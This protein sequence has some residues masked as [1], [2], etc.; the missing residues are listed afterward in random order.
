[1]SSTSNEAQAF[2]QAKARRNLLEAAR[3]S[4]STHDPI[5]DGRTGWALR[6]PHLKN[7]VGAIGDTFDPRCQACR[8]R[9]G[10]V[11]D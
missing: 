9:A 8:I 7:E 4:A 5:P 2:D 6:E 3:R 11:T 1:M 10:L